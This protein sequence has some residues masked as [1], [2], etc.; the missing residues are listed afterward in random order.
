MAQFAKNSLLL[1]EFWVTGSFRGY[2][3]AIKKVT[4]KKKGKNLP[5][6]K[7]RYKKAGKNPQNV[8]KKYLKI[9][10]QCVHS[11]TFF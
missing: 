8:E 6:I 2:F 1:S 5:P 3:Q 9:A 11:N 10:L 7:G 4:N